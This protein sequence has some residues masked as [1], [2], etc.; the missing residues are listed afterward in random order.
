MY[1]CERSYEYLYLIDSIKDHKNEGRDS[2]LNGFYFFFE[3]FP[4]DFGVLTN[5][6]ES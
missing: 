6:L 3:V 2:V 4:L 5:S 1:R